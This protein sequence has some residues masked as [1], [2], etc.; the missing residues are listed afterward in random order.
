[1]RHAIKTSWIN[2]QSNH[3]GLNILYQCDARFQSLYCGC[4]LPISCMKN[5]SIISRMA[6]IIRNTLPILILWGRA[7]LVCTGEL[8][9]R[10]G[11]WVFRIK[12]LGRDSRAWRNL[13]LMTLNFYPRK[14]STNY[15][16]LLWRR[17]QNI[18]QAA[19][20][21]DF[22]KHNLFQQKTLLRKQS[23]KIFQT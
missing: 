14:S 18:F 9:V 2:F 20:S 16:W 21:T 8:F 3:N 23:E 19:P 6:K 1:M 22:Q 17:T 4:L 7:M 11:N 13:F 12:N 5:T 10:L 15:S